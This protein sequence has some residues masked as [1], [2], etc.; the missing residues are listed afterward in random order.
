[1]GSGS[2]AQADGSRARPYQ[3]ARR[4]GQARRTR[5]RILDTATAE[6]SS[7]GYAATTVAAI[8][9]AAGVSVPTIEQVFRTK[10][11]LLKAA[12]DVAIAGDDEPVPMLE[13]NW[14]MAAT[15]ATDRIVVPA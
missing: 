11:N 8:A 3:S 6:F 14:A 10:A 5:Q 12:I 15:T 13:R 4:Q 7:C 2:T 9:A 1:M